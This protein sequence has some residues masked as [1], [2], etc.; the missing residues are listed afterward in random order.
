MGVKKKLLLF[1]DAES[2]EDYLNEMSLKGYA[3]TKLHALT[4]IFT[5]GIYEFEKSKPGE[6][7]YRVDIDMDKSPQEIERYSEKISEMG[8]E[9]LFG[10]LYRLYSRKKGQYS[11]FP[12]DEDKIT[13]RCH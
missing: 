5:W 6:Y 7:T 1:L 10:K 11:L 2:E 3:L 13:F 4:G 9:F 8:A 12:S